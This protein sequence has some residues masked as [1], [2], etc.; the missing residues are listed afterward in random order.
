MSVLTVPRQP[1]PVLPCHTGD[2]DLWFAETP[3]DLE[4]AKALCAGCPI[5]RQCLASALERAEPW[6]VWGGE[7]IDRGS[8]LGFKRPR[9]RPRKDGVAA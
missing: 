7:I 9:G 8:I 3:A 2:P 6:G 5:R 4:R 1:S